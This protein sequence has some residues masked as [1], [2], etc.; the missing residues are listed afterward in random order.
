M[1]NGGSKEKLIVLEEDIQQL[2][3]QCADCANFAM[4][5]ADRAKKRKKEFKQL[6]QAFAVD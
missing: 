3:N 5:I 6:L 1:V 4:M 2:A